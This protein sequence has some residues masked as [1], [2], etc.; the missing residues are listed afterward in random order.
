MSAEPLLTSVD[1]N[2]L[3][4]TSVAI[5]NQLTGMSIILLIEY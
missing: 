3:L 4:S 1:V 5:A 2:V